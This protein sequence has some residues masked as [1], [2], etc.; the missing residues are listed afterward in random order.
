MT[1]QNQ[2]ISN[3][4]RPRELAPEELGCLIRRTALRLLRHNCR[5]N[6]LNHDFFGLIPQES[7]INILRK[8]FEL[9]VVGN[10]DTMIQAQLSQLEIREQIEFR[11]DKVRALYLS[12]IHI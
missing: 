12:L 9:R 6:E 11:S 8:R 2:L 5:I 1:S 7:L 3:L 10:T 4:H